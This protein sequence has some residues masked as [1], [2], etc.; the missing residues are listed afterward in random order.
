VH[1][2]GTIRNPFNPNTIGISTFGTGLAMTQGANQ[3]SSSVWLG[4]DAEQK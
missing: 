1:Q 3:Q 4:G 2:N